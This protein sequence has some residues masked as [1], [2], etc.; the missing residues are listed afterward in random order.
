VKLLDFERDGRSAFG[1][2]LGN[3]AVAFDQLFGGEESDSLLKSM[4]R[5]LEHLPHSFEHARRLLSAVDGS[6]VTGHPL[7]EVRILPPISRPAALLDF[8]LTPRHLVQS[9]RT[10]FRHEFG[11]VLGPCVHLLMKRRIER[12]SKADAPLYYKGNHLAVIGNG[13]CMGWPA[14]TSYLDI[15]PELAVVTGNAQ[16]RIAGY[17]IFN[18]ASARDVQ[19][20]EM[21]GSGPARSKDFSDSNG[22]GPYLVTPDEIPDPL[23]LAVSVTIGTRYTWSGHT[24]EYSAHPLEVL[25]YYEKVFPPRPGTIIGMGTVPGCTGLDNDLWIL[26]GEKIEIH[27]EGL[28]TLCQHV[29]P[30]IGKLL[31]SRWKERPELGAYT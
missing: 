15:E 14:Y 3:R 2:V 16:C 25:E 20:S 1:V 12:S 22:I 28:G 26:P 24:A 13:D 27:M 7:E 30:K 19:F 17:T 9:A 10:L 5:Y 18:D 31:E 29:P 23:N 11:P 8:G 4:D 21:I 6:R